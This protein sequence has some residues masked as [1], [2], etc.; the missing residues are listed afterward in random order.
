V[1]PGKKGVGSDVFGGGENISKKVETKVDIFGG[2][3]ISREETCRNFKRT[4]LVTR[5]GNGEKPRGYARQNG[6]K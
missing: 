3:V 5:G 6:Y 2:D 4:I 1:P